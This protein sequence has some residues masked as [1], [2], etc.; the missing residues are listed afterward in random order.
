MVDLDPSLPFLV[1][2]LRI[3]RLCGMYLLPFAS[4]GAGIKIEPQI[5]AATAL[6]ANSF[7]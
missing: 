5:T 1:V 4:T 2:E 6:K 7:I 3:T